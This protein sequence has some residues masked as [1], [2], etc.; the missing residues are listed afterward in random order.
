MA[1]LKQSLLQGIRHNLLYQNIYL[2]VIYIVSQE[3]KEEKIR[4]VLR[5]KVASCLV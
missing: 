1:S 3:N 5:R 4:V 2:I